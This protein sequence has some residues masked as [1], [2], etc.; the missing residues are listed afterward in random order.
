M[1]T[2]NLPIETGVSPQQLSDIAKLRDVHP[3][4]MAGVE[5][6]HNEQILGTE[7]RYFTSPKSNHRCALPHIC[8]IDRP[9]FKSL[10]KTPVQV[11]VH[12]AFRRKRM[13]KP[14]LERGCLLRRR[15]ARLVT[16]ANCGQSVAR[17]YELIGRNN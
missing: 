8:K 15:Q 14:Q 6:E 3:S 7:S 16:I 10:H 9:R 1:A 17:G 2:D 5:T 11:E 12:A 13:L 4:V